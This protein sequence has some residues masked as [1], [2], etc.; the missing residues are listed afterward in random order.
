MNTIL[1]KDYIPVMQNPNATHLKI[2]VY[3]SLGGY[4]C[5]TYKSEGRGYYLSVCPVSRSN[6]Y[7]VPMESFTAFTGTKLLIL[8]CDRQSKK[9]AEEALTLYTEKLDMLMKH[10][11]HVNGLCLDNEGHIAG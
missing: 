7:G 10:V 9:R 8:P 3:Y 11:L 1:H 2:E 6:D 5:F 4:N